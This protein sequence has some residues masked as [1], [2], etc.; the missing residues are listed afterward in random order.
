[1]DVC[2][3][4]VGRH[5]DT[6]IEG[7]T[8]MFRRR[9][10]LV[11]VMLALAAFA[12]VPGAASAASRTV[13]GSWTA[14]A[15]LPPEAGIMTV[16]GGADGRLYAFGFCQQT[17]CAVASGTVNYGQSVAYRYNPS[18]DTWTAAA[19]APDIC[20]EAKA[21]ATMPDGRIRLGGCWNDIVNDAGFKV[22]D[23]DPGADKWTMEPGHGPYVDPI[24]AVNFSGVGTYWYA[25]TLRRKDQGVFISGDRI[26]IEGEDG[27]FEKRARQPKHGPEDGIGL[28]SDGNIYVAG[29][30]RECFIGPCP[31]P[32]F[33]KWNSTT[34]NWGTRKKLPGSTSGVAVTNDTN[35]DIFV[36]GGQASDGSM[37]SR[38][39]VYRPDKHNWAKAAPVPSLRYGAL[40]ASTPDGRV[41]V[42]CGY[43][44]F[45]NPLSDGYVFAPGG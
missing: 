6:K 37:S 9:S 3:A 30:S 10:G 34:N 23:Y 32:S 21:S 8:V 38:A 11:V 33:Q 43:D 42:I 36:V 44:Q 35:G 28:G 13:A 12:A 14:I 29:G 31:T 15:S 26:I 40:A 20:S 1:M 16:T 45:G 41:W 39:E 4:T 7:E 2:S 24:G 5:D 19:P 27:G 22:A 25:Q 17:P 18:S